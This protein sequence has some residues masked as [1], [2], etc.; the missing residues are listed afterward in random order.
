MTPEWQC[1][2]C[3]DTVSPHQGHGLC[4]ACFAYRWRT[5]RDRPAVT[6]RQCVNC[7]QRARKGQ[8]RQGLCAR[9]YAAL[10]RCHALGGVA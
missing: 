10:Y 8:W 6:V 2:N 4:H 3:A 9:C 1:V 5:G 7:G